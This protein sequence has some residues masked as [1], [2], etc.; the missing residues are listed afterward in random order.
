LKAHIDTTFVSAAVQNYKLIDPN[1][2]MLVAK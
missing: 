1:D 2:R